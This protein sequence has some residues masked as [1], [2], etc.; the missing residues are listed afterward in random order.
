MAAALM[1]LGQQAD[2]AP[3]FRPGLWQFDR[4]T[5]AHGE[6]SGRRLIDHLLVNPRARRCVD[7]NLAMRA[8]FAPTVL[9]FCRLAEVKENDGEYRLSRHCGKGPPVTTTIK[10]TSNTAFEETVEGW[11]G[12]VHTKDT[13]VGQRVGNCRS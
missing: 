8:E 12:R 11:I 4:T 2:A 1:L 9:G 5:E 13:V 10:A 3:R 7:P 6:R